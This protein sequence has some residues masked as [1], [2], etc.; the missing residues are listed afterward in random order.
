MSVAG[1]L[2]FI[3]NIIK[4][5]KPFTRSLFQCLGASEVYAAWAAGKRRYD[6]CVHIS[7][8]ALQDLAWW[9]VALSAP[10]YRQPHILNSKV[11]I[12]HQKHEDLQALTQVGTQQGTV[13]VVY[14]SERNSEDFDTQCST[15]SSSM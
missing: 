5:G 6:P 7:T 13:I 15:D 2:N 10:M 12:W 8:A 4:Q 1:F 3:T 11:F 9:I 14:M